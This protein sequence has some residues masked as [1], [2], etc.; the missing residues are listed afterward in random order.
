MLKRFN[1]IS[2]K[3]FAYARSSAMKY[4]QSY[5][6]WIFG[7]V[8]LNIIRAKEAELILS[9]TKHT[10]KS[11]I[12][13]FLAPLMGD[14]LLCSKGHKWKTR[15]RILS[16]A[17]HFNILSDFLL[18]FQEEADKLVNALEM[19]ADKKREVVLQSIITR[20]TL[21]TICGEIRIDLN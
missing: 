20:F 21:N 19:Y 12:Y 8:I 6:H 3:A 13:R 11:I 16:P 5:R 15:R 14:G 4:G 1:P 9:S 17:F 10:G 7:D 18:V 2:V